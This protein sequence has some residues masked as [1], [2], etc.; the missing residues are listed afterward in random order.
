MDQN[1]L[2]LQKLIPKLVT[3]LTGFKP[4][5]ENFKICVDYSWSNFKHHRFLS[6]N[7][8]EIKRD[9]EGICQKFK[10]N[11]FHDEEKIMRR[12]FEQS[13]SHEI[14][15]NH[16]QREVMY[17]IISFL[18]SLAYDP[19]NKLKDKKRKGLPIF[20]KQQVNE[21]EE[22][23]LTA[24]KHFIDTLLQDNFLLSKNDTDSDLSEWTE[25]DDDDRVKSTEESEVESKQSHV[26]S[27]KLQ[28]PQKPS[29]YEK[30]KLDNTLK[31]LKDNVQNCWWNIEEMTNDEVSSSHKAANFYTDWQR[32]L[33][34]KSLG[35][36]KPPP[37]SLLSEYC[38]L[39]EILWMFLNPVNCKFFKLEIG[40]IS[41]RHDVCMPSTTIE[42]LNIFLAELVKPMNIMYRLKLSITNAL[43]NPALNHTLENYYGLIETFLDEITEFFV[44]EE[45]ILKEDEGIYT[46]ITLHDKMQPHS[47]M[48]DMLYNIHK[49]CILNDDKY[50]SHIHALYLIAN[51]HQHVHKSSNK[52][53]K[54]LSLTFLLTCLKTYLEIFDIWWTEARLHD[55]KLEF[56]VEKVLI[57]DFELIQ[58]RLIA[59]CK[60]KAFYI[61]DKVSSKI[62]DDAIVSTL[63]CYA[64]EASFTLEV[65]SKLDRIHEIKQIGDISK[66]LY[67]AF[68]E[69]IHE[70]IQKLASNK[71]EIKKQSPKINDTIMSNNEKLVSDIGSEMI[72]ENDDIMY[73]IFNS[74]FESLAI[75]EEK[76]DASPIEMYRMLNNATDSIFMPIEGSLE[77]IIRK[78]LAKKIGI[79]ERFVMDIYFNEFQVDH[80]LQDVRKVYFL[81]SNEL[82]NLFNMTLF[83]QMEGSEKWANS[84]LLTVLFNETISRDTTLFTVHVNKILGH[85]T[86]L[87]AIDELTIYLN[88]NNNHFDNIFTSSCINKY[89]EVFRFLLKIKYAQRILN[90]LLFPDFYKHRPPYAKFTML[91]LVIKRI[92][93][94]RFSMQHAITMIHNHIMISLQS[95]SIQFEENV[96]KTNKITDLITLHE[97]FVQNFHSK[98]L[99]GNG[100][101]RIRGI[102]SE[103]LK[104]A[105]VITNEWHNIVTFYELD[106]TGQTIDDSI[107]LT[108]LNINTIEIEKAFKMC[109]KQLKDLLYY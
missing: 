86:V 59:K 50:P 81:E 77:R 75:K 106:S 67:D 60:E 84:Y 93:I 56:L 72:A 70:E 53:Q 85:H 105:K 79:A 47:K 31:W 2:I 1:N 32:H 83:S 73:L 58:P 13:L 7:S 108:K 14:S 43:K 4:N 69:L 71:E 24:R 107:S 95:L 64:V 97:K 23:I 15:I 100:S 109:E 89:N 20:I 87:E 90:C 25:S 11:H 38:L 82:I 92:S 49:S 48:L 46:I 54:N 98:A 91:D 96:A 22:N 44:K 74:T 29:V 42:S 37:V 45:E 5:N 3:N 9:I 61:S 27:T 12:L 68:M 51:L 41:L 94:T 52:E 99:L 35:F 21:Q 63:N 40:E 103:V 18:T 76:V 102:V 36:I 55:S 28:P 66:T 57:G 101:K 78:L 26:K 6:L 88:V 65:I 16:P 62:I 34:R 39:R 17:S 10:F 30:V 8:H 104:L 19:I 33:T 80:Y